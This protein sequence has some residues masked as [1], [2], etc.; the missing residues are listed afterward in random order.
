MPLSCWA[1][2]RVKI[3]GGGVVTREAILAVLPG[4]SADPHAA[5]VAVARLRDGLGDRSL[6]R[7]VPRRG[8]RLEVAS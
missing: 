2:L 4:A 8:Y 5:E 6:V 3:A 1:V 7:T